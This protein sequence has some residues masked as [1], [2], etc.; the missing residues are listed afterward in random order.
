MKVIATGNKGEFALK[1]GIDFVL[2]EHGIKF[3]SK[4]EAREIRLIFEEPSCPA[5]CSPSDWKQ[6]GKCD[7]NGCYRHLNSLTT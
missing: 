6:G 7:K 5:P 4:I 3:V 1:E 2:S